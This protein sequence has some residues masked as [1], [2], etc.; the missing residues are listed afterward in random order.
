[1]IIQ[2]KSVFCFTSLYMFPLLSTTFLTLPDEFT[3]KMSRPCLRHFVVSSS[4]LGLKNYPGVHMLILEAYEVVARRCH[5]PVLQG[6]AGNRLPQV[7]GLPQVGE[8]EVS[9]HGRHPL[10]CATTRPAADRPHARYTAQRPH[11]HCGTEGG[12]A[13]L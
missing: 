8:T 5:M 12:G 7:L 6:R 4:P 1:M 10:R 2:C 13:C 9:G 3:C 11:A